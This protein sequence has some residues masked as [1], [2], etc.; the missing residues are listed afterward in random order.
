MIR[1][2]FLANCCEISTKNPKLKVKV[3]KRF[4]NTFFINC[5]ESVQKYIKYTE[6]LFVVI[7]DK[8]ILKFSISI[9]FSYIFHDAQSFR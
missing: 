8:T 1:N 6:R 2:E 7:N 3:L 4:T 5:K 9:I